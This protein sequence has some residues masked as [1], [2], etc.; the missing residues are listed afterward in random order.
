M[1]IKQYN[2][3]V[4]TRSSGKSIFAREIVRCLS[5]PTIYYNFEISSTVF[6]EKMMGNN[7][8]V[9]HALHVNF[10]RITEK[11]NNILSD[12][13][14]NVVIDPVPTLSTNKDE[15]SSF[16]RYLP[17]N[18]RY[19][20]TVNC[21]DSDSTDIHNNI[22]ENYSKS[23]LLP[24]DSISIFNTYKNGNGISI[25]NYNSNMD[26]GLGDIAQIIRDKKINEVLM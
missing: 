3:I 8:T 14:W 23:F 2:F 26:F 22:L 6:V 15:F 9:I 19:F 10:D 4:G 21:S 13:M 17:K 16:F 25:Y 5:N 18:H 24:E 11:I 1:E 7:S 12:D 20:F